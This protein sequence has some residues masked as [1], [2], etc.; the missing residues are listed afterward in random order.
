MVKNIWKSNH[1][2]ILLK[3][4]MFGLGFT[5]FFYLLFEQQNRYNSSE[6][7]TTTSDPLVLSILSRMAE[8]K[9]DQKISLFSI[10]V[11]LS[12]VRALFAA[13]CLGVNNWHL[14]LKI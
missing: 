12:F 2:I 13:T 6:N 1:K 7:Y 9:N 10:V 14:N 11:V 3:T 8:M 5:P 4:K